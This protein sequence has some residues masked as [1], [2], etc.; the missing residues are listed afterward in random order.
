[1]ALNE[2]RPD[3]KPDWQYVKIDETKHWVE[4][5]N[6]RKFGKKL[7]ATYAFNKNSV[8][9]CCSLT[10]AYWLLYLGTEAQPDDELTEE[11]SEAVYNDIIESE[12]ASGTDGGYHACSDVDRMNFKPLTCG[13]DVD[14]ADY[15]DDEDGDRE[16]ERAVEDDIRESFNANPW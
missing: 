14:R 12:G 15:S 13:I 10:P 5:C 2:R 3:V 9:Y 16:Y 11:Q 7:I 8:T 6:A 4:D 1:M